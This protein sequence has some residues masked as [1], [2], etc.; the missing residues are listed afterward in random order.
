MSNILFYVAT[1]LLSE[2]SYLCLYYSAYGIYRGISYIIPKRKSVL[3]E[4]IE[5]CPFHEK[6]LLKSEE[7]F[8]VVITEN[9]AIYDIQRLLE[10]NSR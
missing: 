9:S 6:C 10:N 5:Y 4:K 8:E 3:P 2:T 7:E 1:E